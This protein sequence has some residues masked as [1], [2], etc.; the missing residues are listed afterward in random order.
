MN[1]IITGG[2]GFLGQRLA[3]ALLQ[4]QQI[5]FDRLTLA[6]V[7]VPTSPLADER[8][9]CVQTDLGDQA[10]VQ[11]LVTPD[12]GLIYHLAAIV[13]S[14]AEADFDLG[15]RVNIDA[16]RYLLEAA[17]HQAPGCRFVFS[18]SL[19][20]FGGELPEVI[21][22]HTAVCPQSSYGM[23]KSVGELLVNDY[24]R[25]GFV[26]G[27]VLRLPT[28]SVRPGK[29]NKAAS[30]FASGI[31]REPL[32]GEESVCPVALSLPMWLSSPA[33]VVENFVRAA[34]VPA[35]AFGA[36]RTVNLPGITVTVQ[37]MIDALRRVAG[38][39]VCDRIRYEEDEAVSRIVA[40]WPGRFNI[41]R[42]QGLGFV[43]DADFDSVIRRFI[44]DDMEGTK[45]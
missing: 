34:Q 5:A 24:A 25:K 37:E 15:V 12:T 40:S 42:A 26:D 16:T 11:A 21:Q 22:D 17:R 29:P 36:S 30:S 31:I 23:E 35:E 18:S 2:A 10:A 39:P 6:D 8:V 4:Q 44:A 9:H 14:H 20:V 28:I 13:S 33:T 38:D 3:K 1:I 41:S 32:Q 27:R 43:Q 45:Q 19:A 7:I